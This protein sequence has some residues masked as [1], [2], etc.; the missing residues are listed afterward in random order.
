MVTHGIEPAFAVLGALR[1]QLSQCVL[2]MVIAE[3]LQLAVIGRRVHRQ[4]FQTTGVEVEAGIGIAVAVH[5]KH[6]LLAA[7][8]VASL[9]QDIGLSAGCVV[10]LDSNMRP[11]MTVLGW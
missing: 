8:A 2:H 6:P 9:C 3:Q 7:N 4:L 11:G 10:E 5:A 1:L